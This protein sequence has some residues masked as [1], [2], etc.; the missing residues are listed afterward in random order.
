MCTPE[1][2]I[3]AF[4][5]ENPYTGN[6][7]PRIINLL[8]AEGRLVSYADGEYLFHAGQPAENIY[9]VRT[10][11]VWLQGKDETDELRVW[12]VG[13]ESLVGWSVLTEPYMYLLDARAHGSVEVL[14]I[15]AGNLRQ[16]LELDHEV[17]YHIFPILLKAAAQRIV[18]YSSRNTDAPPPAQRLRKVW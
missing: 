1:T 8:A 14:A 9:L 6:L 5:R 4:L 10:G 2:K 16:L 12:S 3:H 18:P 15:P 11:N 7:P 17:G 13:D